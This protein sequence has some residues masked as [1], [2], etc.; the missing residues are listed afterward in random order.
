MTEHEL[1]PPWQR[2]RDGSV[3]EMRVFLAEISCAAGGGG[4][5]LA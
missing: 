1:T 4:D 3:P 5:A 2:A